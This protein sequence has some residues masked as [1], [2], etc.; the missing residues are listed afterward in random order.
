[1]GEKT[2]L[3]PLADV[4]KGGKSVELGFSLV[5]YIFDYLFIYIFELLLLLSWTLMAWWK[6]SIVS[7]QKVTSNIC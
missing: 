7:L 3:Y 5:L 4:T 2:S 1:M 6:S